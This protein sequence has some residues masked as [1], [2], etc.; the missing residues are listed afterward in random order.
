MRELRWMLVSAAVAASPSLGWA[1]AHPQDSTIVNAITA[2]APNVDVR[3]KPGEPGSSSCIQ[4]RDGGT[5]PSSQP[6]FVVDGVPMN[7]VAVCSDIDPN[8]IESVDILK[9][10]VA[11][12]EF[13]PAA[14][15]GAV[16]ITTKDPR[17]RCA[18]VASPQSSGHTECRTDPRHTLVEV[19]G[20][21]IDNDSSTATVRAPLCFDLRD[22]VR[23]DFRG[24][25][26]T[27]HDSSKTASS[28][29]IVLLTLREPRQYACDRVEV[30][31]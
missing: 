4:I 2:K 8:A 14:A 23:V 11:S 17:L 28:M 15:N 3:S 7:V 31:P 9:G 19:N 1:Q 18:H 6:L 13:G 16:L 25:T 26:S 12:A 22:L 30:R 5:D 21:P 20:V 29:T 24:G 27:P 10:A